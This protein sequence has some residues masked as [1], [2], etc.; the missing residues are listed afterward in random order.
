MVQFGGHDIDSYCSL[1]GE[2]V[3]EADKELQLQKSKGNI[4]LY[5]P[6]GFRWTEVQQKLAMLQSDTMKDT[7]ISKVFQVGHNL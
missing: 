7:V 5:G 2:L 3:S 1:L 4:R 6:A